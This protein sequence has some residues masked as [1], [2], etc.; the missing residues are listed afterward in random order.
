MPQEE[1]LKG[2]DNIIKNSAAPVSFMRPPQLPSDTKLLTVIA[3]GGCTNTLCVDTGGHHIRATANNWKSF[4][5]GHV[6]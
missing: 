3:R 2:T 5:S 4:T 6:Q 1:S